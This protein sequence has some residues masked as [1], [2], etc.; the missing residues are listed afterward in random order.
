MTEMTLLTVLLD[1]LVAN[2][3]RN[4][5]DL[6]SVYE[7]LSEIGRK[8]EDYVGKIAIF[9]I[10]QILYLNFDRLQRCIYPRS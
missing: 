10:R 2:I 7:C 8:H 4:S 1:A 3:K 6:L 5:E 9:V